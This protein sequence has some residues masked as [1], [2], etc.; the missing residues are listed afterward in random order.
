MESAACAT[1][2]AM[3]AVTAITATTGKEDAIRFM[4][5]FSTLNEVR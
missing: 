4:R 1:P 5:F 3:N 2:T